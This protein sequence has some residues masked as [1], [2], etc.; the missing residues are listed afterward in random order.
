MTTNCHL[1]GTPTPPDVQGGVW[2]VWRRQ[3]LEKSERGRGVH[4]LPHA[5]AHTGLPFP[6]DVHL[7]FMNISGFVTSIAAA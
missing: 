6:R 5:H 2:A 1:L 4:T 7:L 3:E